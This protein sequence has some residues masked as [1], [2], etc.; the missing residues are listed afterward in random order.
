[1]FSA[2]RVFSQLGRQ[3]RADEKRVENSILLFIGK[4]LL[5]TTEIGRTT[6]ELFLIPEYLAS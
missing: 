3:R 5:A 2:F 1:M 4:R 6:K